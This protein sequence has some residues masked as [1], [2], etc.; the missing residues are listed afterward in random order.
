[1]RGFLIDTDFSRR[2]KQL[3]DWVR[4]VIVPNPNSEPLIGRSQLTS[5]WLGGLANPGALMTSLRHE[6]A[7]MVGCS[8]DE[9]GLK[10]A[11]KI[12]LKI[13]FRL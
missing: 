11:Y 12:S 2:H 10:Q 4:R 7:A 9:V 3:S 13:V 1:M 6:K 8:V 5:V